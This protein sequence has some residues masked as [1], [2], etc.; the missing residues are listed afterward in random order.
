MYLEEVFFGAVWADVRAD[1][2]ATQ[3]EL[4]C[5]KQSCFGN[6]PSKQWAALMHMEWSAQDRRLAHSPLLL[7]HHLPWPRAWQ[8]QQLLHRTTNIQIKQLF[9]KR[10]KYFCVTF[11]LIHLL[12][13]H[14]HYWFLEQQ[15]QDA[16]YAFHNHYLWIKI[17]RFT[18]IFALQYIY[19]YIIT[20][21][22]VVRREAQ[23]FYNRNQHGE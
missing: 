19:M 20:V 12:K 23:Y 14:G 2:L 9:Q 21:S 15:C 13:K 3:V 5:H 7:S 6:C 17:I 4:C 18:T 11:F 22:N 1:G 8:Q 10:K 16:S